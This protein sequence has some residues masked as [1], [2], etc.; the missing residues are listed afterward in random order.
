MIDKLKKILMLLKEP[1]VFR[2]LISLRFNGFL[3]D[4]GWF[5]SF[6]NQTPMDHECL[7]LPWV[8]YPFIRFIEK[9]LSKEFDLF[10]YGSGNSTL[11][12]SQRVKTVTTVEHDKEWFDRMGSSVSDNVHLVFRSL[13]S[14]ENYVQA[15]LEAGKK[16]DIIIVD[17]R[18]RVDCIK[19]CLAA[20]K[21]NGVMVLDDSERENYREGISFLRSHGFRQL[22]FWGIAPGSADEKCTS[23]FYR[24][25]NC[26][27]I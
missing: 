12:Y 21:E 1:R 8:T 22:D 25:G 15:A 23:L 17:G 18:K 7:P 9:R 2:K 3:A 10:E 24:P 26:F 5:R 19:S 16:F 27:G 13:D 4:A 6:K 20:L 11:F 14:G